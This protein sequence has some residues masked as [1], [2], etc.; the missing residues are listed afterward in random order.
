MATMS[1]H[2]DTHG[3][4]EKFS[5]FNETQAR[6]AL[7]SATS[8]AGVRGKNLVKR[9]VPVKT[10]IGK[11]GIRSMSRG[12]GATAIA[13]IYASGPHAHIVRWQDQGTGPR[14]K[15][16]GQYT[17][18]VEPQYFFERATVEL[19]AEVDAIFTAAI[20]MALARAGLA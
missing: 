10:G 19:D 20:D 15:K 6:R 9:K 7:R 11:A 2:V 14:H 18:I 1:V 17:G 4:A 8:R 5:L 13:K 3:L 12:G 16:N